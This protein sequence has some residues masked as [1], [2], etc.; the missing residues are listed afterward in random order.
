[1]EIF[2]ADGDLHELV[3]AFGD[4]RHRNETAG[5]A[6]DGLWLLERMRL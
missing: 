3:E 6:H 4:R 5:A 1:M 2:T